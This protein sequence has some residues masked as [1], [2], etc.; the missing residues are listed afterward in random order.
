MKQIGNLQIEIRAF[1]GLVCLKYDSLVLK[2]DLPSYKINP[3]VARNQYSIFKI[4]Q[5][6][7]CL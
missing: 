5:P 3:S 7:L 6:K 2:I 4:Q 1:I